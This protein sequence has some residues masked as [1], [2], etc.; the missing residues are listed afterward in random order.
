[1]LAAGAPAA[2]LAAAEASLYRVFLLDG[3]VLVS[4]GEFARVGDRVVLSIPVGE[5]TDAPNLQVVSIPQTLVDWGRTDRYADAVRA[6]R[7]GETRGEEDFALLGG[8]VVEALSQISLTDD[9]A[10]RL[11][12]ATEARQNLVRWPAENFGYRAQDV[13]RLASMLD[14]VISD[15]RVAAG[16]TTR[17]SLVATTVP[18]PEPLLAP[19]DFRE[20]MEQAA[21]AASMAPDPTERMSLLQAIESSLRGAAE[22][23][24]AASLAAR[25]RTELAAEL[26]LEKA[27]ESLASSTLTSASA[28]AARG[29]LRGVQSLFE[30]VLRADDRLG[31][32]RPQN[33]SALLA[34]LEWQL[35]EAARVRQAR[36]A[37]S[38]RLAAFR[39]YRKAI[40]GPVRDLREARKRLTEIRERSG[41]PPLVLPRLEQRLVMAGRMLRLI[42]PPP[43]LD[44]AHGLFGGALQMAARAAA[45]RRNALSSRDQALEWEAAS[46][47]AGALM[48]LD[49]ASEEL[50]RLTS[51]PAGR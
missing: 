49:R 6:R 44:A 34:A 32:R 3:A 8:R 21:V 13:A 50:A 16:E 46:A 33:T 31:R 40:E 26:R 12:M 30:Q 25:V 14:E 43:E 20:T 37:W 22:A 42:A 9:P 7:Y 27:Y 45:S 1:M 41:P 28:R 10:R 2:P 35:G 15:L 24:W 36:D 38:V 47:A 51:P 17:V 29:D 4:Y 5:L 19:P 11:A 39:L 23:D 48:L 18:P